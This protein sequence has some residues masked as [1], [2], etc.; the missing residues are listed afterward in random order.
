MEPQKMVSGPGERDFLVNN[1]QFLYMQ[2]SET[3]VLCRVKLD[4]QSAVV[5]YTE[6]GFAHIQ[7]IDT[8]S[9]A[10]CGTSGLCQR[11]QAKDCQRTFHLHCLQRYFPLE[12]NISFCDVHRKIKGKRKEYARLS[13]TRQVSGRINNELEIIK[14]I[15][16]KYQE[17]KFHSICSGQVFWYFIGTQYFPKHLQIQ[18]PLIQ[19]KAP[20]ETEEAWPGLIN[21]VIQ[22]FEQQL[23]EVKTRTFS[24]LNQLHIP[25]FPL[26]QL[27]DLKEEELIL[28][29]TRDIFQ[30][31]TFEAYLKYFESKR[32]EDPDNNEN[33]EKRISGLR[34]VPKNEEDFV[35]SICGDGDYEDDDLIV[36][37]SIC[38]IGAHMKCYGIPVV[39]EGDWVCHGCNW[40]KVKE[41]RSNI[42]CALCPVKG[43]CVKPT[44]HRTTTGQVFPNYAEGKNEQVWCHVFCA[45]HL[46][47]KVFKDK[48]F[49]DQIDLKM[50]DSKRFTLKCCVCKTKDGACLQCQYGRC[51][52]AFHPECGKDFFTNTRDKTGYDEVGYYCT[53]HKPLKLRR[54]L[55]GKDK[56]TVEDV[57]AFSKNFEKLEK[58]PKISVNPKK[59]LKI[60]RPF[61]YDERFKLIDVLEHEIEKIRKT[62]FKEFAVLI[63]VKSGSLRNR[64]ETIRPEAFN[65]IDPQTILANKISIKG[66]KP[67]ECFKFYSESLYPLLK[68]ELEVLGTAPVPFAVKG[69]KSFSKKKKE[70][71][72]KKIVRREV[73]D[74]LVVPCPAVVYPEIALPDVVT[75]EVYCICR[76]PFIEK[77]ARKTWE[78]EQDFAKRTEE[79]QMILC[80][81]CDEWYH[82][83]CI[84]VSS[85]NLPE[86]YTCQACLQ[87][88]SI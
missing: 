59:V 2:K 34:E 25:L 54:V 83:K 35:C 21:D 70:K 24:I 88:R 13:L 8:K 32:T 62:N 1:S 41:I 86:K 46:E 42:S 27:K 65:I 5:L 26:D 53:L 87:K 30:K 45:F 19:V 3:C 17:S 79:S 75:E 10:F 80:D 9:C 14:K 48:D 40:F 4:N 71:S 84:G 49:L 67:A 81:E 7:C 15:K 76:K 29:E 38:E 33:T 11:C 36:I 78:S 28:N 64:V 50:M 55:E 31:E 77:S 60:P 22:S 6:E 63:K 61:N 12:E 66:R 74:E 73:L 68:Q 47:P 52:I 18:L 44:I 58:K 69:R 20:R 57:L 43:G 82:Y 56:K 23:I 39:P 37:C 51:Q 85:D 16:E 72:K